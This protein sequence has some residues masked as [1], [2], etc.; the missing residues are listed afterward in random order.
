MSRTTRIADYVNAHWRG[1]L[2]LARSFW[3]N[4]ALPLIA[5]IAAIPLSERVL[6]PD[7]MDL[8]ALRRLLILSLILIVGLWA[9]VG[10]WC[11]ANAARRASRRALWPRIA[12]GVVLATVLYVF[13]GP[14]AAIRD[15]IAIVAA[16][17]GSG[18]DDYRVEQRGESELVLIGAIS[19]DSV[20]AAIAGLTPARP[21]LRINSYGGLIEPAMRLARFM[22]ARGIMVVAEGQC[23]SACL[24]V[25]AASPKAAL[26]PGSAVTFHQVHPIAAYRSEQMRARH[27]SYVEEVAGYYREFGVPDWAIAR[28]EQEGDW[29]P[30]V[31]QL[32]EIGI[33]DLVQDPASGRF[34][35]AE[36][37]C[38][39]HPCE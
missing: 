23:I 26:M 25:L 1:R 24:F 6:P 17:Q 8:F 9:A 15:Y 35:P 19:E 28:M 34:V 29:T 33:I 11:S 3:L 22:R 36:A 38:A 27:A 14:F 31:R 10:I 7:R 37:Y 4:G 39:E 30:T 12:Q 21:V 32:L 20:D 5:L 16:L 18:Y 13:V 2:S